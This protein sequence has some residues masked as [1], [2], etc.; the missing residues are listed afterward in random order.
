MPSGGNDEE[1]VHDVAVERYAVA[2]AVSVEVPVREKL[3]T[4]ACR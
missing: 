4:P 3:L 2:M 1:L